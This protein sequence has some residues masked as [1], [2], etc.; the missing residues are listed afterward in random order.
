MDDESERGLVKEAPLPLPLYI[1]D[2]SGA[3]QIAGAH[4]RRNMKAA[5]DDNLMYT[6]L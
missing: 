2:Q 1:R 4:T 3:R 5:T 6:C